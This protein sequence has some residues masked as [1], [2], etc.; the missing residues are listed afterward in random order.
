MAPFGSLP[1]FTWPGGVYTGKT[2]FA[3][4]ACRESL[5]DIEECLSAQ[6]TG[7]YRMGLGQPVGRSTL[8]D[9][10]ETRE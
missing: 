10:N 3:R 8:A 5:R 7:L 1:A 9:A 6:T 2:R 4:I